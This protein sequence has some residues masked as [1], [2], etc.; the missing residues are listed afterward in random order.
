MTKSFTKEIPHVERYFWTVVN[1]QN[2]SKILGKVKQAKSILDVQSKKPTQLEKTK[3]NEEPTKEVNKE[4]P[5]L[6]EKETTPKPKAK[7]PLDLLPP[8]KMILDDWKRLYSNTKT[9][10]REVAVK[11]ISFF[12]CV[13]YLSYFNLRNFLAYFDV[14]SH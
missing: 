9:N 13:T 1:Q 4:E 2:F 6:V 14:R 11:G 3:A 5:S 10:F 8:S 12:C 7:N